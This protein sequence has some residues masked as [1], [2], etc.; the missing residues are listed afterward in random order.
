MHGNNG[1][2]DGDNAA[3]MRYTECRLSMYGQ[4]MTENLTKD[5]VQY[6]ANFDDSESE[7]TL[8]PTFL[9]N[10]LINGASGIAAGY[11]TN[12]PPFNP[13]EVIDAIIARID[14]PNCHLGS[15][16]KLMPGP[17]FPTGGII[18]ESEGINEAYTTGK[19]K[20]IVRGNIIQKN[21]K[22]IHIT[23]I[24]YEISRAAIYK[25]LQEIAA[26]NDA[27]NIEEV[28]DESDAD[29]TCIV[30]ETKNGKNFDVIKN[31]I[32]KNTDMQ[33]SYGINMVCIHNRKPYC[34]PI[35]KILDAFI[36]HIN[37]ITIKASSFDLKKAKQ[38]KEIVQGLIKAIKIL[39]DVVVLIRGAADKAG[40]KDALIKKLMFSEIQAEA[41]VSLRL[42]NLTNNDV[43]ELNKEVE[44]LT[45][46]ILELELL[47]KNS[48]YRDT[49]LKNKLRSFKKIFNQKRKT[50]ISKD[51]AKIEIDQADVIEDRENVVVITRDGYLKNISKRSYAN[52][53]YDKIKIKDGDIPVAQ[54]ISNL[55][56][57]VI[58][59]SS[60]GNYISIPTHKIEESRW[61][62]VGIHINNIIVTDPEEKIINAFNFPNNPEDQRCLI[63]AT[64]QGMIKRTLV[65]DLG[66]SR[67]TKSSTIINLDETDSVV[68]C[69]ISPSDNVVDEMVVSI[70]KNGNGLMYPSAQISVV[71]RNAAGV[72]NMNLANDDEVASVF[73]KNKNKEFVLISCVQGMKR[74]RDTDIAIGNRTNVGKTIISQVKSNPFVVLNAF[75]VNMNDYIHHT[76][77]DGH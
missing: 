51:S 70:S 20:I 52:S 66:I 36:A 4:L 34:C 56:D 74:I 35:T 65:K 40:A 60:K 76:T 7:P 12:I 30:I 5:T 21:A 43:S 53:E 37:D 59:V 75:Y 39:D 6:I 61:S 44:E 18:L 11:A 67:I 45:K 27:L 3:A 71:S 33:I 17:D 29:G 22:N 23:D 10:L 77:F 24:P 26:T 16:L 14:S 64:K 57:K 32:Y 50:E 25:Q 13:C 68:S 1:S 19:G 15:I 42:Y 46:Q 8:L 48:Q 41:I 73:I 62:D 49:Y 2:I 54:F 72:K 63:I 38:R 55:R 28:R 9:P 58:L 47:V 31:F 69:A